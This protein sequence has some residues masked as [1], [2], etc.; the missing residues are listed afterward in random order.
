M[1]Q[2]LAKYRAQKQRQ[3]IFAYLKAKFLKMILP[4]AKEK[5]DT[6]IDIPEKIFQ[7]ETSKRNQEETTSTSSSR[8]YSPDFLSSSEDEFDIKTENETK[9]ERSWMDY[10]TYLV[11]FIF[12]LTL[13]AIAIELK[14]GAVFFILSCLAGIYFNTRTDRKLEDEPSAYSVF[15]P[16][17]ES[18]K[19]TLTADQ[20][21]REFGYK[22]H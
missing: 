3:E 21:E 19:G 12:W 7:L 9:P 20:F 6:Q 22:A 13:Y 5:L 1:E 2:K 17:M 18:I 11:W 14:F 4:A 8:T 10:A 15:N 16:N